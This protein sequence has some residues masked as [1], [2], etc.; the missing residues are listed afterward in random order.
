MNSKLFDA[1][2]I[3]SRRGNKEKAKELEC[4]WDGCERP[5]TH[6]A[7]KSHRSNGEFHNFCLAHV[8]QY[9]KSFNYFA[10]MKEDEISAAMR[11]SAKTGER[12]TWE[13]GTNAQGRGNPK[14]RQKPGRN[15]SANRIADPH[16]LFARVARNQGRA[17]PA[18]KREKRLVESDRN[19][20]EV[21][22][23]KGHQESAKIKAVYKTLVKQHHP[24]A[25]GGDR[26]SEDRLRA[27]I[28]AYTHLK[29]KGFVDR[30]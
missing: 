15:F 22:G 13:M 27:I 28:T 9:N 3:K 7:P 14:P 18:I 8:R 17:N 19:A 30:T 1:V 16:N 5:G 10:E 6:R 12:P 4:D 11:Q 29:K 26:S 23:L 24:D 25:N 2:R 21:L 20:L